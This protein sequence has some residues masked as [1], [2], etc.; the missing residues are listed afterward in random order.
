MPLPVEPPLKPMLG[1][2]VRELPLGGY[3]YEPK[4]DGFRCLAFVDGDDVDLRSRHDRP[5]ARYF[6]ELVAA[7]RGARHVLDGEIVLAGGFDFPALMGRL[8]PARSRAERLAVEVPAAYVAFDLVADGDEDLRMAPFAERRARLEALAP[9]PPVHVTPATADPDVAARWLERFQGAGL[10]GVVAKPRDGR[11]E[12]GARSLLKV[13]RERTADCVVAGLRFHAGQPM[14]GSLLL[15]LYDD[16]GELVHVGVVSQL[17][18]R[19]RRELLDELRPLAV[20]LHGHPW[21]HGY[22]LQGGATGRL[23]GAAA[24]WDPATMPLDWVPLAPAR[25]LEVA[26]DQVDRGR[27]RHPARFR[28]WR[29]DRA[30]RSCTFDQLDAE[31]PRVDELLAPR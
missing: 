2:L 30:P 8:H 20:P 10:D 25:V 18:E 3:L 9:R 4:W 17:A 22:S 6:P 16:E 13:K 24:R 26:Y 23:A 7:L 11:Y 21:E 14:V 27:F 5:L 29:E 31:A 12:P 15:G 1:R 28:R 19:R